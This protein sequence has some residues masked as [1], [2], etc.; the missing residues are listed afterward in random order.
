[1]IESPEETPAA[2]ATFFR[3]HSMR[4]RVTNTVHHGDVFEQEN[5]RAFLTEYALDQSK[6]GQLR[7]FQLLISGSVVATR[8]GIP[9]QRPDLPLLLG[10]RPGWSKYSVMTTLVVEA[11]K[12]SIEQRLAILHMS[13]GTD[14]SKLR[15]DPYRTRYLAYTEVPRN[16][17]ASLSFGIYARAQRLMRRWQKPQAPVNCDR[18]PRSNMIDVSVVIPTFRRNAL[19][20]EAINS[21]LR[22]ADVSVEIIVVDDCPDF[23][24]RDA[25]ATVRDTRVHYF[26]NR[27]TVRRQTRTGAQ[28]RGQT[29]QRAVYPFSG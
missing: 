7:I 21:A 19:L 27:D 23:S 2:L 5:E 15:W 13:T 10:L 1:M 17:K 8:A 20:I 3:L 18:Q 12:W 22:Q 29:S 6:R 24:A 14:V 26:P 11:I 9:E 28:F 25:V 16:W 4:S